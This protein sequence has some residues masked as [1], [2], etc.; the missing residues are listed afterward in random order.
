MPWSIY[1]YWIKQ[2][3]A[4]LQRKMKTLNSPVSQE[5]YNYKN[6]KQ[7]LTG[8]LLVAKLQ[9]SPSVLLMKDQLYRLLLLQF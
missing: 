5:G 7:D 2:T 3:G 1:L 9:I 8:S 4:S 6:L